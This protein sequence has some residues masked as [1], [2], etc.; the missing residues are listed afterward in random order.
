MTALELLTDLI[1]QFEGCKL[2]A[3]RCPRGIPTI[4]WGFTLGVQ[5]GDTITQEQ[6]D[7]QLTTLVIKVIGKAYL[8]SP[9]LVVESPERVA[10]I[11]DFIYNCGE[12]NYKASTLRKLV[13]AADWDNAAIEILKWD[14]AGGKALKGL[15]LRRKKESDLLSVNK[16]SK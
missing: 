10:A 15:T 14:K 6:A 13:N 3:Y 12:G 16:P 1:K 8:L 5:M 9:L 4:G 7:K 11:A 2:K